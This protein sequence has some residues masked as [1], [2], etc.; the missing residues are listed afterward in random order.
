MQEEGQRIGFKI[1]KSGTPL[2]SLLSPDGRHRRVAQQ[3]RGKL[4]G[5][6]HCVPEEVQ[7]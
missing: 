2:S 6:M 5:D 1:E 3:E 7:G 4:Q